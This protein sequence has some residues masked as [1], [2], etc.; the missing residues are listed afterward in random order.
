MKINILS[1]F[2]LLTTLI[3][4]GCSNSSNSED[5]ERI[6]QLEAQIAELQNN[7]QSNSS[8]DDDNDLNTSSQDKS[9]EVFTSTSSSNS[10]APTK[11]FLGTYKVVDN[12][13]NTFYF[14]LNQDET[15]NV[16][17]D[18]TD[19][20][21]YCTWYE[22]SNRKRGVQ[23]TFSDKEPVI[24]FDGGILK[25][26]SMFFDFQN[27]WLYAGDYSNSTYIDSKHPKWRLKVEKI[28]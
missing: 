28:K 16:K 24:L 26:H 17:T 1:I 27:E 6:A 2:A 19:E 9:S 25:G 5:K 8:D 12:N 15:A 18:G 3:C 22:W 20:M 13:G 4:V 10:S 7:S 23:I 11:N 14:I 21:L